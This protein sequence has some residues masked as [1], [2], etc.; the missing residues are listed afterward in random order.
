[1][2]AR[3]VLARGEEVAR[4]ELVAMGMVGAARVVVRSAAGSIGGVVWFVEAE[5]VGTSFSCAFGRVVVT[6][7]VLSCSG[8][9]SKTSFVETGSVIGSSSG[10]FG[11]I[12]AVG[13]FVIGWSSGG[14]DGVI[15]DGG[16]VLSCPWT[17]R[18]T[19]LD[20]CETLPAP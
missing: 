15:C 8:T 3:D 13:E 12:V 19:A 9:T 16:D 1:M 5:F 6:G 7:N 11:G 20:A 14:S 10:G 17:T 2:A 4:D 18:E